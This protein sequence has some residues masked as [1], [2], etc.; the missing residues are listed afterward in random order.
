MSI[1]V[2]DFFDKVNSYNAESFADVKRA[3]ELAE[4]LHKGQYRQSGEEY[5]TH[6]LEVAYILADMYVD[7]ATLCAALLHDTV[8]DTDI[9]LDEIREIFN[10]DVATLVDGVTKI[11]KLNFS[12]ASDEHNANMRKIITSITKDIRIIIIKLASH[13]SY[14]AKFSYYE[15]YQQV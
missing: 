3:Y 4:R 8:E 14:I 9:T 2:K 1:T 15:A 13:D 6:P 12:C 10:D 11:S 7:S 5:I